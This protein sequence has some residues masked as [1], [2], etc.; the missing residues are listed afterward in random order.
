VVDVMDDVAGAVGATPVGGAQAAVNATYAKLAPL[1]DVVYGALLQ[2]GRRR[3]MTRLAAAG[4][5]RIL[6]VG[7]GTGLTIHRYPADCRAIGIDVSGPMLRRAA[8]RKARHALGQVHLGRMD[9]MQLGF[10]DATFDAVYVPYLLN[11]VPDPLRAARELARVC[12]PG[13]RVVLLNHF[14]RT[15][16]AD[17]LDHAIGRLAGVITDVNWRLP[18][19]PLLAA[20]GLVALSVEPVNVPKVSVVVVCR[21]P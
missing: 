8:V 4:G 10:A 9:A 13:G 19:E 5:E 16:E 6:E 18:L 12:R 17:A 21:R 20:S 11:V 14:D 2:P 1:Y 3:A 15:H 7:V